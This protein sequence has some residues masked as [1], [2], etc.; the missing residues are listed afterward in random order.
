M[1]ARVCA[2]ELLLVV[3]GSEGAGAA[4]DAAGADAGADGVAARMPPDLYAARSVSA[5]LCLQ[6]WLTGQLQSP[7]KDVIF[8]SGEVSTSTTTS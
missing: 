7:L 5:T 8:P 2:A 3:T 4:G 1:A 6:S